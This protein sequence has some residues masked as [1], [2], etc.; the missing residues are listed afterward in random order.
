M[1]HRLSGRRLAAALLTL[2]TAAAVTGTLVTVPA[3]AATSG[4]TA[5]GRCAPAAAGLLPVGA[6]IVSTGAFGFVTTC[7]DEDGTTALEWH[8]TDGT[9]SPLSGPHAYDAYADSILMGDGSRFTAYDPAKVTYV[10]HDISVVGPDAQLVG[11]AG[12]VLYVSVTNAA[13][14]GRDLYQLENNGGIVR[15]TKLTNTYRGERETAHK[16]VSAGKDADGRPV[17]L[18]LVKGLR[19]RLN[20]KVPYAFQAVVPVVTGSAILQEWTGGTGDWNPAATGALAGK[21]TAWIEGPAGGT[22]HLRVRASG[23][24]DKDIALTD[25]PGQPVLAGI[26]GDTALYA[27]QRDPGAGPDVLTPLYA[28]NIATGGAPY[29]VLENYSSVAHAPD[30]SLLVRGASSAADGLFKVTPDG[31]GTPSFSLVADTGK[32]VALQVTRSSVPATVSLEKPG[33]TVPMSFDLSRP[34]AKATLVLTHRATGRHAV[35]TLPRPESGN[36]FSFAWNGITAPI[37]APNGAYTWR[38]TATSLDGAQTVTASGG[39]TVTRL[40]NPHDYNDNGSTDVLTRDASGTLW[41][42]D[43]FDGRFYDKY[44]TALRTKVGTGWNAYKQVEAVGS[45]GGAAHGDVVA[46]DGSGVT[47][48]YLGK[49]DGT[50]STR[51]KV[52]TGW[53]IYNKIAGGSDLDGD[54]RPDLVATDTAGYLWFYKGTGNYAK[55]FGPRLRV[56]SGWNAYNQITAV[57]NIANS[58]VTDLGAGDL[59]ARDKDGVLWLYRGTGGAGFESRIRIG[60]GWNAFSQLVGAGD[61]TGDGRPDLIAYGAGGTHVYG[62][63][64][65]S[66]APFVRQPTQLFVGE[67]TRYNAVV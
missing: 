13:G 38:L 21:Y 9:V 8:K 10:N 5:E 25:V 52:G 3:V 12:A 7:T 40:N 35:A 44:Q 46:V 67:G 18:I 54:G 20:D 11:A 63:T 27:A 55:P 57:G 66:T 15:K 6:E 47:W 58:P 19:D 17:V 51:L 50:F 65:S 62:S 36:R 14:D 2:S 37:S 23:G 24:V 64:G 31:A 60:T 53:Q 16:V 39:F 26:V 42:D 1:Q 34:D 32:V 41:R 49:G 33:A 22:G 29:K 28:R 48:L 4:A 30:G 61:V 56:S 43:L 45:V 59:V